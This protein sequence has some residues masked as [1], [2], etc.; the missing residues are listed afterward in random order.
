MRLKKTKERGNIQYSRSARFWIVRT[1]ALTLSINFPNG[2]PTKLTMLIRSDV[3]F[4]TVLK[5]QDAETAT[6]SPEQSFAHTMK[7]THEPPLRSEGNDYIR[8]NK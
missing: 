1:L 5:K 8:T 6:D 7:E 4:K 2:L 3:G